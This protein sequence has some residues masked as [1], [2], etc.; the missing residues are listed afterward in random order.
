[1]QGKGRQPHFSPPLT[2]QPAGLPYHQWYQHSKTG[3][4]QFFLK[5]LHSRNLRENTHNGSHPR[6]LRLLVLI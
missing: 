1:M 3:E 5:F 6:W 4:S 2:A